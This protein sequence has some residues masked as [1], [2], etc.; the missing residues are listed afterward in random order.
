MVQGK[1]KRMGKK[2][3]KKR[4]VDPFTKKD[5]FDIKA[6]NMFSSKNNADRICGKTMVNRTQGT[7]IAS[8]ALKGRVFEISL[9]DLKKR[10]GTSLQKNSLKG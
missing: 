5:W 9:A 10:R 2:G 6:P 1:N 7:H 3:A 4:L 8:D